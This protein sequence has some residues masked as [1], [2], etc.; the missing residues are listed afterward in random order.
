MT[1][2]ELLTGIRNQLGQSGDQLGAELLLA[3][4]LGKNRE[5]L[6]SHD[7]QAVEPAGLE[8]FYGLL[9]RM[10]MGEPVAY[11][12][13]HKEFYGLDF[14]VDKRVLIPRPETEHLVEWVL[15]HCRQ[16]LGPQGVSGGNQKVKILDVGTGSGCIAISLAKHL[17]SAEV[18]GSDISAEALDVARMNADRLGLQTRVSFFQSDLFESID[19]PVDIVIANLPYIGEKRFS[20]V[21]KSAVDYEPHVALFGGDD[22]LGLYKKFFEQ[23]AAKFWRPR[24][25]VGEFGFLQKDELEALFNRSF[26][27]IRIRFEQDYAHIDRMFVVEFPSV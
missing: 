7:D 24:L 13:G 9:N 2:Q 23:L 20:F 19:D 18:F 10:Q 8:H 1:I 14:F 25:M 27:G 21:S 3:F 4:V 5:Y 6:L 11:L 22:G 15:R 12:T 17:E 16:F 26:P